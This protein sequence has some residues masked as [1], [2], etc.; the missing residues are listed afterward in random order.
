MRRPR[1]PA[2]RPPRR[3]RRR[4]PGRRRRRRHPRRR[5]RRRP[6]RGSDHRTDGRG[7]VTSIPDFTTIE[8][9]AP[10]PAPPADPAAWAAAVD[11]ETGKDPDALVWETPEG[12]GV[13]ALYTAADVEGLDFL[14]TFP[15]I[16]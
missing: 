16:A 11:A 13:K 9:G 15:G 6:E 5:R 2:P 1:R 4:H 7:P 8:L 14:D 12:I 10:S 3:R